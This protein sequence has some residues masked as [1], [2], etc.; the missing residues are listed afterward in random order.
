MATPSSTPGLDVASG[1]SSNT[2]HVTRTTL[3]VIIAIAGSIA[4][5]AV[6]WTIFR[7][8]KL[9]PSSSFDDRMQPIDWQ[10]S[11]ADEG[12]IE[13]LRRPNSGGSFQSGSGHHGDAGASAYGSD[14]GHAVSNGPLP[15]HDFTAG[16]SA[17]A[18]VGGY[19]DLTR[20][21]S[22]QPLMQEPLS[23]GPSLT[24]PA[25]DAYGVPLH[26]QGAY[27]AY[28]YNNYSTSGAVRY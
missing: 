10:P 18:P 26:H 8:W 23:R 22:P 2:S 7:K 13:K 12:G 4:A 15:D 6:G 5:I 28:D 21:P 16:A 3:T 11:N 25:Y 27:D 9:K 14:H 17:L 19:A 20:G 24:R 1:A